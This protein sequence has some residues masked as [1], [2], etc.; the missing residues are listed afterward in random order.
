MV[1]LE[2]VNLQSYNTFQ[3]SCIARYFCEVTS[4]QDILELMKSDVYSKNKKLFLWW[5]SNIL[6]TKPT[7]DWL[8]IKNNIVQKD[9]AKTFV[10]EDFV[11][12]KVWGGE[13][14]NNFVERTIDQWYCWL[15]N[16]ISIP[17]S[18]W[19]A[20][21]QNIWAY[22]LEVEKYIVNVHGVDLTTWVEVI[23]E[24][25]DCEFWYRDS[26][27]KRKLK[28]KY[29]ITKVVFRLPVY[30]PET[31]SPIIT[32]GGVKKYLE[33]NHTDSSQQ[34]ISPRYIADAIAHIRASKLPDR[35][36]IG[37]AWSFFKNPFVH[38][39]TFKKLKKKFPELVWYPG[40]EIYYPGG[41]QKEK[42]VKLSAGQLI[43]LA[44]FKWY[45][46]WN[47]WTYKKHALVLINTWGG[48]WLE[49][50]LLARE[51]QDTVFD[52]FWIVITPEVNYV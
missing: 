52:T 19:A 34:V 46:T 17:G 7:F 37:T 50:E 21:L 5:G 41:I 33:E 35:S 45:T 1:I 47:V 13:N 9:V 31:Y 6:L 27:F 4:T 38:Q 36:K 16:L 42:L 40:Q 10:P 29:F 14:R 22:G 2:H 39:N 48:T 43:D 15:E 11:T 23:L 8:V 49:I 28:H 18:V 30:N 25:G 51:I 44:W 26:I 12:I 24:H 3:I 32:Y 20:P